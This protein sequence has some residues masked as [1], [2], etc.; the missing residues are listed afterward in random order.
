VLD[1]VR[2]SAVFVGTPAE[3]K[4]FVREFGIVPYQ[5]TAD[6]LE[7]ARVIA[8]AALFVGNQS[9]PYAIAEALKVP[10]LQE[11]R[12]VDPNCV[13]LRPGTLTV[14]LAREIERIG[15]WIRSTLENPPIHPS[16]AS[17]PV[18]PNRSGGVPVAIVAHDDHWFLRETLR[19]YAS[20]GPATV[21][22]SVRAWNGDEGRW[23]LCAEEAT[24]AGAEVL[25]GDW[26][27][28]T[29]HRRVAL[30]E[31]RRRGYRHVIIPDS[32]EIADPRLLDSLLRLAEA[33]AADV[34]RVSMETY[35]KS[36]SLAIRPPERL[37]PVLMVNAQ[38]ARQDYIR[39]YE[40]PRLLVLGPDHGILHH[41]S[42]A[43]PD[44]RIQ[45]KLGTWGHRDEVA[46]NWYGRVWIGWN[47][48]PLM[49]E[50]H[51]THPPFYGFV[52]RVPTPG[53]LAHC[54][55]DWP[56][57][58]E[59]DTPPNW[60]AVSV[61]IPLYGGPDDLRNLLS[62]LE[63][64]RDLLHETIV[65]D[66][67][68]P[69]DAPELVADFPFARLVQNEV[70]LGFA[71]TCNAGY[72]RSTGD[73]VVFLN[74]DTQVPR[75][76]L[77]RLVESLMR[78]ASIGA[79]G[80]YTSYSGG[81]QMLPPTYTDLANMPAFARD[82]A[83]RGA[84]DRDVPMLTGFCL[85][86][87]RTALEDVGPFDERFGR[88]M[89]EDNDLCYRLLRAGWRLRLA[90]RAWVHHEGTRSM[91]RAGEPA[92]SLL[93]RNRRVYLDKW[94]HEVEC[95][96]ASHLP[97]ESAGMI[98]FDASRHPDRVREER[99]RLR[100][101]ADVSLCMIVRNEERVLG[102]CLASVA[103]VF[104]Q[105]IVVDT[106][107]T[108]RTREIA[109]EHG[110]ELYEFPWT[111]SFAEA[112]NESLKY[113]TGRWVMWMDADDTLPSSSAEAILRA[114]IHAPEEVV[115]FVIPVRFTDGGVAGGTQVDH[116]KLFRRV[117]GLSFEGRIHEQVLQ[118]LRPHGEI[119]RL[120]GAVVLH[121]GYDTSDEG[122]ARKRAR[123]ARL[124]ELDLAERPNHPFVLFNL[125]MTAHYNG[126]HAAAV[127]WLR[128]SVDAA[129]PG[130]SHVR[131]AYALMGVS[132]REQGRAKDALAVFDEG[133]DAVGPDPELHF[134]AALVLT[135]QG[136]LAEARDRYLAMPLDV[137][138]HFTSLDVAILGP[139]RSHNLASVCAGMGD[140][141][142]ARRHFSDAYRAGFA[143]SA[144]ALFELAAER[145]DLRT[146][147]E[148]LEAYGRL[149]GP[150]P[151]WA[152]GRARLAH[153]RGEDPGPELSPLGRVRQLL[154]EERLAEATPLL[155]RLDEE[156][157]AEA[158]FYR[159]VGALREGDF[160][161][162]LL[163]AR[164]A[165]RLDPA[166]AGNAQQVSG[167]LRALEEERAGKEALLTGPYAGALGPG[168]VPLSVVVVTYNS[169]TLVEA[170][171][172]AALAQM[173]PRDELILV[174]NASADE[175]PEVLQG[176]ERRDARVR[177]LLGDV[178]AGY[179]KGANLGMR[180]SRGERILLMNPDVVLGPG[181]LGKMAACLEP[182]VGAVAPLSDN[183][184][185]DQFVSHHLPDDVRPPREA[186]PETV[187]RLHG[188]DWR[189]TRMLMGLCLLLSRETLDAYGLL[190]EGCE[191]GADDLELSWRLRRWGLALRVAR[192]A[193]AF[194]VG[195]A[196]FGTLPGE[197]RRARIA[198]SDG[199]LLARLREFY[200]P[201]RV[202]SSRSLWGSDVFAEALSR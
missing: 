119:A 32:D 17:R 60:P 191:L 110:A 40:G 8:G 82:F 141:A 77:V 106:G 42:Y 174:D 130:E 27:D 152:A 16:T 104:R 156:G 198:A 154:A 116:V 97:G 3:H 101:E 178:N 133:L 62:S 84:E 166:N 162:A 202:P 115:G 28:E 95:G 13:Y 53:P 5:P 103:G 168:E 15:P 175:T 19:A 149:E 131:K 173:G 124:L 35:W 199:A 105:V 93:D 159:S 58:P 126:E 48:D 88:G 128:R 87:R 146:A 29:L 41:L 157:V 4:E 30:A 51:P 100:E 11:T 192:G 92:E 196:S 160:A 158:A 200:G 70:N 155:E 54:R 113:A 37:R 76:G 26:P 1:A 117:P 134:Q 109:L 171:A 52:E 71:G 39:E 176:L 183:V 47:E 108:D 91:P 151:E 81:E 45:R 83:Y 184:G 127:D 122:Q 20:S 153:L 24:A 10:A 33:D 201:D 36:P 96:Y 59:L 63:S 132:L 144:I 194:H 12:E 143:P 120:E 163:H 177:V 193:F 94:T 80:P 61:V 142:E 56:L 2:E 79:A 137:G 67:V 98:R 75:A 187:A 66:D 164:R 188:G 44:E 129:G 69:D 55:D 182:G 7:L 170:C 21:F 135:S 189:E 195:G 25:L 138:N 31:M 118:S 73:V 147:R 46:A 145:E 57:P 102:D 14:R 72:A 65:V 43:G 179:A 74:S 18:I 161:E 148:A 114:A 50:L 136:R 165:L 169:A 172:A 121:S 64:C 180:A 150:T 89:Y 167:L 68:S 112:R 78:D 186:L 9:C 139:K 6:L 123:D 185:G 22:V 111:E 34:V 86:V 85:A 190:D 99:E 140:Y 197:E 107:S 90:A 38:T 125:G 23:D 181:G 49:R